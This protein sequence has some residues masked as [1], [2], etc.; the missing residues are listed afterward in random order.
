M[1]VREAILEKPHRFLASDLMRLC[2]PG[3]GVI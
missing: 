1:V 2:T 3:M